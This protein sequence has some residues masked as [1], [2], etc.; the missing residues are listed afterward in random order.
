M[1]KTIKEMLAE[2]NAAIE[3]IPAAEALQLVGNDEVVL[4]DIRDSAELAR[5]GKIPGSIHVP[6]G[7]LEFY[8]DPTSPMHKPIFAEKKK[9]VFY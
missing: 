9:F 4:V 2:A 1:K 7:S 5:D 3:T 6:R 8:V